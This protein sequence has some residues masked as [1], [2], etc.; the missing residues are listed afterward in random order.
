MKKWFP[1]LALL[2]LAACN[3]NPKI[4]TYEDVLELPLPGSQ[5]DTL[6]VSLVLDYVDGGVSEEEKQK[7]N[8]AIISHA[9]DLEE[10]DQT[11]EQ[12][13]VR[14][15]DNLID[16]YL[17]ENEEL[18]GSGQVLSWA[19]EL[20]GRFED[21]YQGWLNYTIQYYSYRG[22]AH[23]YTTFTPLVFDKKS[24]DLV[25]ESDLFQEGYEEPLSQLMRQQLMEYIKGE[26]ESLLEVVEMSYVEPNE[27]FTLGPDG[28]QWHFQADEIWPHAFGPLSVTLSWDSLKPFLK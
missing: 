21:E 6:F 20:T 11:L 27:N 28:V 25:I 26:D 12:I 3:N 16:E 23:G 18:V 8:D 15:R 7:M 1:L 19:D 4:K 2:L 17:N 9:F 5:Q 13:A 24:G 10:T 22:G 14:Y